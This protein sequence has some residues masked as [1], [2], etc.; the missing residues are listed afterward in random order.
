MGLRDMSELSVQDPGALDDSEGP[1]LE[2]CMDA[3]APRVQTRGPP[4]RRLNMA[5]NP[6][7]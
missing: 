4:L 3:K 5:W 6:R 7:G 2:S 1:N